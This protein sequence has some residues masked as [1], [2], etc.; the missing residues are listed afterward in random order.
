MLWA[1]FRH[2]PAILQLYCNMATWLLMK[3]IAVLHYE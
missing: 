3:A 1:L 2:M